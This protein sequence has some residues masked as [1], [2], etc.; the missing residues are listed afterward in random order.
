EGGRPSRTA[1]TT[2][3]GSNAATAPLTLM[4]AVSRPTSDIISTMRRTRLSPA[5]AIRPWPAHAV[6]PVVSSPV[7]TTNSEAIKMTAGSP[8]PLSDWCRLSTPV[9]YSAS[10]VPSATSTTGMA[11][12]T[13]STTMPATIAKVM[14][15]LLKLSAPGA[16]FRSTSAGGAR[17]DT[18]ASARQTPNGIPTRY[19]AKKK[20]VHTTNTTA[21]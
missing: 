9:A 18:Y 12:D 8:R 19:Q 13:N 5:R 11:F 1:I 4:S 15:M 7:L 21:V 2:T 16:L 3:T 17:P 20:I 10:A 6:T 14:V